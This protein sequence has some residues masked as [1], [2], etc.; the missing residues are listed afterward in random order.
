M[1]VLMAASLAVNF[2]PMSR[3]LEFGRG[4]YLAALQ[5]MSDESKLPVMT[6]G[7]D[8]NDRNSMLINFFR[9]H[10]DL[11]KSQAKY[12][13]MIPQ[14]GFAEVSP[15]WFIIHSQSHDFQPPPTPPPEARPPAGK[16]QLR[17]WYPYSTLSGWHWAIYQ[18]ETPTPLPPEVLQFLR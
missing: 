16:Y 18:T 1:T 12:P 9:K 4:G 2:F 17:K 7:S 10:G 5:F 11:Q 3:L 13:L 14:Q 15:E 6:I 8:H